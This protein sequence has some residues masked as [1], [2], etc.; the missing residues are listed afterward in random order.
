MPIPISLKHP[1]KQDSNKNPI[2]LNPPPTV[3]LDG[4]QTHRYQIRIQSRYR[5]IFQI[6]LYG[7]CVSTI[8][9][10]HHINSN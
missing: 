9:V 8:N 4:T 7:G 3:N 1:T 6:L 2:F 10:M 5:R